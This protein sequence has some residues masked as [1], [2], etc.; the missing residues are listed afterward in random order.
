MMQI[1]S[2]TPRVPRDTRRGSGRLDPLVSLTQRSSSLRVALFTVRIR[3]LLGLV[4]VV[5]VLGLFSSW[6][7][8]SFAGFLR[9]GLP[10]K[11]TTDVERLQ[12][13]ARIRLRVK[14]SCLLLCLCLCLSMCI[15]FCQPSVLATNTVHTLL[16]SRETFHQ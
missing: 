3:T 10:P 8:A 13:A 16:P 4:F 11:N 6:F 5:G 14:V 15:S 12:H 9:P 7:I 1:L 2:G